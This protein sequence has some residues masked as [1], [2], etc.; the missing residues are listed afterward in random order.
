MRILTFGDRGETNLARNIHDDDPPY[1]ILSHT[2][3]AGEEEI[4]IS[5]LANGPDQSQPGCAAV[6]RFSSAGNGPVETVCSISG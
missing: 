2:W 4:T 3:G 5:D 6:L 1:A